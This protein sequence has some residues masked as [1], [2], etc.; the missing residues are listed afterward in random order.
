MT[1]LTITTIKEQSISPWKHLFRGNQIPR[2]SI[3]EPRRFLKNNRTILMN[4]TT[5]SQITQLH[6]DPVTLQINN[7][8]QL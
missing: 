8:H 5:N 2:P 1:D 7:S 3:Q 6:Q 4:Y